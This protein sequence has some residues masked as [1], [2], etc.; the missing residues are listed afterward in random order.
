MSQLRQRL[1][2]RVRKIGLKRTKDQLI[3][4]DNVFNFAVYILITYLQLCP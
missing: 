3:Y 1:K 4:N 2:I